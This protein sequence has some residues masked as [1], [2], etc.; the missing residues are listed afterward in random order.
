MFSLKGVRK[1][2]LFFLTTTIIYSSFSSPLQGVFD[3]IEHSE[4]YPNRG[5]HNSELISIEIQKYMNQQWIVNRNFLDNLD[6]LKIKPRLNLYSKI[7]ISKM[8]DYINCDEKLAQFIDF[9]EKLQ[10]EYY[11]SSPII[12]DLALQNLQLRIAKALNANLLFRTQHNF[13][14]ALDQIDKSLE[15]IKSFEATI[16]IMPCKCLKSVEELLCLSYYHKGKIHRMLAGY[17]L[18]LLNHHQLYACEASYLEA[19]KHYSNNS[20]IH[21]SLGFLYI[22]M[23]KC[24]ESLY[25][26][27]FANQQ[28]PN[29]P[30]YIHGLAYAYFNIEKQNAD[31]GKPI[32]KENLSKAEEAYEHAIQLFFEFQTINS[33]I[34]LDYGKLLLF[35]DRPKEA[36]IEFNKGLSIE[37]NH[38]LLLMERGMLLGKSGR[39]AEAMIDFKKGG[40]ITRAINSMHKKFTQAIDSIQNLSNTLTASI[41]KQELTNNNRLHEQQIHKR[42][43][44]EDTLLKVF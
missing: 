3:S 6:A 12:N 15:F 5:I 13:Q 1:F 16:T 24:N 39:H 25:H 43:L 35:M 4:I 29:N 10:Q 8:K 34:Y 42:E 28:E 26:H 17:D 23:G 40:I 22:D 2:Y 9:N 11:F 21:S 38:L 27:E 7:N 44:F 31:Q 32:N 36:L 37:P 14:A 30:D 19:L 33:R 20:A 41:I 18:E